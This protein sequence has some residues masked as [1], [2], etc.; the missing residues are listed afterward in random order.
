MTIFS[1][2]QD[3]E[4]VHL[5]TQASVNSRECNEYS[6]FP[7]RSQGSH[8]YQGHLKFDLLLAGWLVGGLV[9]QS[10]IWQFHSICANFLVYSRNFD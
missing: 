6:Q 4:S 7:E 9:G 1:P 8:V 3:I 10:V 5:T 2:S